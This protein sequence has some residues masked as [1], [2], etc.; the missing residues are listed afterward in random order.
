MYLGSSEGAHG[1][2]PALTVSISHLGSYLTLTK[3]STDACISYRIEILNILAQSGKS[4]GDVPMLAHVR[5]QHSHQRLLFLTRHVQLSHPCLHQSHNDRVASSV[6]FHPEI[7]LHIELRLPIPP[8]V[9]ILLS[10]FRIR[11]TT[12][13]TEPAQHVPKPVANAAR[14]LV[15]T[16]RSLWSHSSST[17]TALGL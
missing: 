14:I 3:V 9:V 6:V 5:I 10:F 4:S 7:H 1:L 17:L 2:G 16:K 11:P 8:K 13:S 15:S 12:P